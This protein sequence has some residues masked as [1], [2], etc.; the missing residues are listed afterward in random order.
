LGAVRDTAFDSFLRTADESSYAAE[1]N[2]VWQFSKDC[3]EQ[4]DSDTK[5][6]LDCLKLWLFKRFSQIRLDRLLIEVDDQRGFT[7][8]TV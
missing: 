3:T 8:L 7:R 5:Q 4:L 1:T 6:R 2:H